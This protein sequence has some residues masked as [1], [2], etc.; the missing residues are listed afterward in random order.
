M[1]G[2]GSSIQCIEV[3]PRLSYQVHG[4][5]TLFDFLYIFDERGNLLSTALER[6]N[7]NWLG[8]HRALVRAGLD[9]KSTV[10]TTH[11]NTPSILKYKTVY[12][13]EVN[14]SR[15]VLVCIFEWT[16]TKRYLNTFFW[17]NRQELCLFIKKKGKWPVYKGNRPKTNT[18]TT[19]TP[20]V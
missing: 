15:Y 10:L 9:V 18:N 12:I 14:I 13:Y 8:K 17:S 20:R 16:Y 3:I 2:S 6:S 7:I 5:Y 4:L 19:P 1:G 11:G